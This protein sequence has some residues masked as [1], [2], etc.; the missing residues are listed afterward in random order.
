MVVGCV[1]L[2]PLSRSLPELEG[3]H[4]FVQAHLNMEVFIAS[5]LSLLLVMR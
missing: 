2:I 5:S 3:T 1:F 4:N